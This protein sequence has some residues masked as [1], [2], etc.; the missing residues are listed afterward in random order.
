MAYK[1]PKR[2]DTEADPSVPPARYVAA[3]LIM[4]GLALATLSAF[5]PYADSAKHLNTAAAN[6]RETVEQVLFEP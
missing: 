6:H 5:A 2:T 3:A 4:L 1:E